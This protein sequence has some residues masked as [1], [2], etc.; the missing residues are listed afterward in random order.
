[1]GQSPFRTRLRLFEP[2]Q[3]V[4]RLI[5]QQCPGSFDDR[6]ESLGCLLAVAFRRCLELFW[7]K[8]HQAEQFPDPLAL[9][10]PIPAGRAR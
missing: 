5:F 9:R 8:S 2:R 4:Q 1:M 7:S 6:R 10:D 3:F